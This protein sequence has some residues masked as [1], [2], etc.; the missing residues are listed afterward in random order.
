MALNDT[1]SRNHKLHCMRLVPLTLACALLLPASGIASGRPCE[2]VDLSSID[3]HGLW[4]SQRILAI[5]EALQR[6]D[7]PGAMDSVIALGTDS[8]YY[9]LV[10]GWLTL[11]LAG[12]LNIMDAR[13]GDVSPRLAARIAFL[14]KAIRAI[15]LE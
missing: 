13:D 6:P 15:D 10:R 8:R 7:M 9:V 4:L 12:D 5:A 11:Q 2:P 3:E 14:Q 1:T